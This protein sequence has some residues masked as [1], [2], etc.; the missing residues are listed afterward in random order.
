MVQGELP[1]PSAAAVR[2]DI[3]PGRIVIRVSL[4][5]GQNQHPAGESQSLTTGL[6]YESV[7]GWDSQE[8]PAGS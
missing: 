4:S 1:V 7:A 5:H 3:T 8:I 2:C 6:G